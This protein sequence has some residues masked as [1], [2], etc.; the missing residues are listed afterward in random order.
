MLLDSQRQ[1]ARRQRRRRR[2][3]QEQNELPMALLQSLEHDGY[4]ITGN[5]S[6]QAR[7]VKKQKT[8][9]AVLQDTTNETSKKTNPKK[10]QVKMTVATKDTTVITPIENAN[11]KLKKRVSFGHTA[12][13]LSLEEAILSADVSYSKRLEVAI[14][15]K[16]VHIV[17]S[18][19][20]QDDAMMLKEVAATIK[21]QQD[22]TY[23]P[24]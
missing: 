22:G 14:K 15:N 5:A 23:L 9:K 16:M 4:D 6:L 8:A 21:T 1:R 2:C 18:N 7:V 10:A 11:K 13:G 24:H 12:P 3:E 20:A 17:T 19:L